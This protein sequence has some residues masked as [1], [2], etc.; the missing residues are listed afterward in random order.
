MNKRKTYDDNFKARVALDAIRGEK[1]HQ[2]LSVRLQCELLYFNP[3]SLYYDLLGLSEES[4]A[5]FLCRS[6]LSLE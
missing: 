2:E 5:D 4:D 6:D 1:D 3:A